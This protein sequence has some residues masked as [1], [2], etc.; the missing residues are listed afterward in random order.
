MQSGVPLA[1]LP[2]LYSHI[3]KKKLYYDATRVH[4]DIQCEGESICIHSGLR[5]RWRRGSVSPVPRGV[6]RARARVAAGRQSRGEISSV[7]VVKVG[8][9]IL[10]VYSV[11]RN[12]SRP[13]FT[14]LDN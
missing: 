7:L 10:Y 11:L 1:H 13:L 14:A 6:L 2:F 4:G 12:F 8:K 9:V 5:K 3:K